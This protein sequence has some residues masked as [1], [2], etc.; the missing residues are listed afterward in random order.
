M[1]ILIIFFLNYYEMEWQKTYGGILDESGFC[2]VESNDSNYIITGNTYSFGNG[3][4]D[5]YIIKIN[6]NG[7]TIWTRCYGTQKDEFSFSIKKLNGN[8]IILGNTQ[9]PDSSE[10][11]LYILKI[12]DDGN[13]LWGKIIETPA[14]EYPRDFEISENGYFVIT[15]SIK[16]EGG[17][18]NIYVLKIDSVGNTVWQKRYGGGMDDFGYS[19]CKSENGYL[20]AGYTYS[21]GMGGSDI[22]I[23]KINEN[24]DTLWTKTFGREEN[25]F[26]FHISKDINE[27]YLICGSSYWQGLGYEI[28]YMKITSDGELIW[29]KY[30]GSLS[31]DFGHWI[32]RAYDNG[33]VITGNFGTL[34]LLLKT[35][36]NGYPMWSEMYGGNG[37]ETGYC[38]KVLK[39]TSYIVIGKTN[40]FGAGGDDVYV[41]KTKKDIKLK[42]K[43]KFYNFRNS[44]KIK[45][46]DICGR[47]IEKIKKSRIYIEILDTKTKKLIIIH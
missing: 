8:Y 4:S 16:I 18:F 47:K 43:I 22:Y 13:L 24:G 10:S 45:I 30:Y 38:V 34:T 46:F 6:R 41:I 42:E 29:R 3:G 23:L 20:V 28:C 7:D 37:F 21:Y 36:S 11:N 33:Y 2:V 19:I 12:D 26:G 25:D 14:W 35:D 40:S 9:N 31:N 15:G 27:N 17:D 39:D 44:K 32:E 1:E 5:I